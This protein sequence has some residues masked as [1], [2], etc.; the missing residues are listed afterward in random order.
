[1][2]PE[3]RKLSAVMFTDIMDY[4]RRM[5]G[6]ER[7]G[8]V[9][10]R[11]HNRI[12]DEAISSYGGT[13]VKNIG[14]AYMIDFPSAVSAVSAAVAAQERFSA[15][16]D[17]KASDDQI[18]ARIS[19]HLGD[20]VQRANDLFGDGVNI[21]SRL[22]A[23]TP[24]GG[25]CISREVFNN[26]KSII[27]ATCVPLGA[28]ELKG[29]PEPVEIFQILTP[30]VP[31]AAR[32]A[33]SA[34]VR[35]EE[36]ATIAVLPFGNWSKSEDDDY[37]SDGITEDII[38]DLASI[39]ALRVSSRNSVFA[40][41]GKSVDVQRVGAELKVRYIL[42]G[43][44]RRSG[45][46]LRITAQ[47]IDASNNFHLWAKRF[48]RA[49][50]EVFDIQDEIARS[51]A[52]DLRI[53]L[54]KEQERAI[55]RKGTENFLAYDEYLKGIYYSRRRTRA[56]MDLSCTHL[57]RAIE[58]DPRF[59][60]AHSALAFATRF[61]HSFGLDRSPAILEKAK[62]H[63]E[64]ALRLDPRSPDALLMRAL[65]QRD[66]GELQ[67]SIATINDA[68]ATRP[69]YAQANAYLGNALRDAGEV[70]KAFEYHSRAAQLDPK[71]YF[72]AYNVVSDCFAIGAREDLAPLIEKLESLDVGHF[73]TLLM[74][75]QA[76]AAAGDEATAFR[77]IEAAIQADPVHV[78]SKVVSALYSLYFGRNEDAYQSIR[79]VLDHSDLR[80]FTM[81]W[82]LF[83]LF[84]L[85]RFDEVLFLAEATLA[86][87]SATIFRGVDLK[88]LALLY[89]GMIFRWRDATE[90]AM[91]SCQQ[92]RSFS[93][94]ALEKFP[95][96]PSLRSF[97]ALVLSLTGEGERA[98]LEIENAI[99]FR[100]EYN[101][102][103]YDR[104]R[105]C[106]L[107]GDRAGVIKSLRNALKYAVG[108]QGALRNEITF[109][110]FA[111]DPEFL[112]LTDP[113]RR[114]WASA[115]NRP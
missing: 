42:E 8:F 33:S 101:A 7:L 89:R 58:I 48:D 17:G 68:L 32:S 45:E 112:D 56:D 5:H 96:S 11:E 21:A 82:G 24:A 88:A 3:T 38:T 104:A 47:L 43:S 107:G 115:L 94:V 53:A 109:D 74:Q 108:E 60:E 4:T 22:Q 64:E 67:E 51:I 35:I 26:V 66:L 114:H 85:R 13:L 37:F 69:S 72:F 105:I 36:D 19:I 30:L 93:S 79:H 76:A 57:Q 6:N 50:S 25:I 49:V 29:I 2:H 83:V 54:T 70:G 73:L 16:N 95:I 100:S 97:H 40:Y 99:Q 27:S 1:M 75:G 81:R 106:A 20:V 110:S 91:E 52:S 98:V 62:R 65:F 113:R 111:Q 86:S 84:S 28:H 55:A 102:C 92:A 78:D 103:W 87:A 9:L 10:I 63:G 59:A 18:L 80:P 34:K 31:Q 90:Q 39:S 14:D 41:K 71:D 46:R 77:F 15:Y 44:V 23:F 12:M 61:I